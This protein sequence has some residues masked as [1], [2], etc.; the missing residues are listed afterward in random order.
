MPDDVID[1]NDVMDGISADVSKQFTGEKPSKAAPLPEAEL[2][3]EEVAAEEEP[4]VEEE[5]EEKEEESDEDEKP[6]PEEKSEFAKV[7]AIT[8][9]LAT[10]FA[11]K[12]ADGEEVEPPALMVEF[13][14]NGKMRTERLDAVVK[15]A[16]MGV[17]NEERAQA[18]KARVNE[19][20]TMAMEAID[21]A[22]LRET[23]LRNLLENEETYLQARERY[24]QE[25]SPEKRV[26]R[27]ENEVS[28]L[29]EKQAQLA[30]VRQAEEF[31]EGTVLPS[32]DELAEAFPEV[33]MDEITAQ[34]S[35]ALVP[36]MR[37]GVVPP[38]MYGQVQHYIDTALRSW[39]E[40]KHTSRSERLKGVKTEEEKKTEAAQ[41]AAAKA[42][43]RAASASRPA[44]RSGVGGG[45]GKSGPKV[46]ATIEDAEEDALS[47]ALASMKR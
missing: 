36:V 40:K 42:K 6:E 26:A 8:D 27:A 46:H 24:L 13:K 34:F 38:A 14:A 45:G 3:E 44:T 19:V 5:E 18:E 31:Y 23:Q 4:A 2:E 32:L 37:N 21:R 47:S 16:Q 43:R 17:Y 9:K 11:L 25:N 41:I 7:A 1:L 29:R 35:A 39:A 15:L 30:Q 33:D 22:D 12:D 20:E 28:T 10:D